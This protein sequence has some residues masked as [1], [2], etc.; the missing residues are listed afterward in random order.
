MS[1]TVPSDIVPLL[2]FIAVPPVKCA[3][4]LLAELS[5]LDC[6]SAKLGPV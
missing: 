5:I 1:G 4:I 6:T 2:K 3:L